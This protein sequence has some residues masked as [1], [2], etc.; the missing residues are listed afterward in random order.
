LK[1]RRLPCWIDSFTEETSGLPSPELFR[2]WTAIGTIASALERR[3][4]TESSMSRVYPNLYVLLVAPPGVGKTVAISQGSYLANATRKLKIAP[5]DVTKASLLDHLARAQQTKVYSP[6]DMVQYHSLSV[7]ADEFGVLCSAH[8]LSFMSVMNALFDNRP[9]YVESRRGRETDLVIENPQVSMLAGT[10]PDFLANLLP[11]EAWGMGFMSRM[12]MVYAG[13]SAKPNLFGKKVKIN[14]KPLLEDLKVIAELHGEVD[15]D[16]EAEKILVDW[17]EKGMEPEPHHTKL[18]HYVPRRIL[19][20]LKLSIISCV[21]RGNDMMIMADD[22]T[23]AREWLIEIESFMPDIFKDMAGNSDGQIIQDLH[24]YVWEMYAK[25]GNKPIH[26][27]RIDTFLMARTPAYNAENIVKLCVRA[28]ILI[29]QPA[30]FYL[31]GDRNSLK[32][33]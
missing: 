5:D 23:R 11:P 20:M 6:T 32:V 17:Y 19:T 22:V 7:F 9:Q 3:V 30:D 33:E 4:Y 25:N 16:P 21:S 28:K 24:Y 13:K 27:S 26:R 1:T 15:W 8:D 10:Q 29:D 2:K 31:P 18:K 12:L 14:T